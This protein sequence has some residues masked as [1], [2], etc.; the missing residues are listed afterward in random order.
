[1][2]WINRRIEK[3]TFRSFLIWFALLFG[4][5]YWAFMTPG[6]WRRALDAAGG[7]LPE[8]QPGVPAIEPIRSLEALGPNNA[9]YLLWQ[10]LDIPYIA[11][12]FLA[13]VA[14]LSIGL[15]AIGKEHSPLRFLLVLP[16]IYVIAEIV[17]NSLLVLFATG[18]VGTSE[19]LVLLQQFA[20]TMKFTSVM[21]AMILVP[22][23]VVIALVAL[24]IRMT[25]K[26]S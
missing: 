6:P 4:Y 12:T 16:A 7:K 3:S 10:L 20:T 9:D 15:K 22:I 1:M 13:T 19:P 2:S 11:F 25:R 8:T 21:P 23:S 26:K 18:I 14:A 5:S 17:E 24:I